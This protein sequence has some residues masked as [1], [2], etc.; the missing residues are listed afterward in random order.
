MSGGSVAIHL[1]RNFP[2]SPEAAG[3]HEVRLLCM[4]GPRREPW[5]E[6]DRQ[7]LKMWTR[8]IFPRDGYVARERLSM[9]MSLAASWTA[10]AILT[11]SGMG[12]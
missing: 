8:S 1:A 3:A 4:A 5:G 11:H 6:V 12:T 10:I 7:M 9:K 2:V